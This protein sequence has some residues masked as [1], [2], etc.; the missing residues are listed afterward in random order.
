MSPMTN[1]RP[2]P[3]DTLLAEAQQELADAGGG[4]PAERIALAHALASARIATALES[5]DTAGVEIKV[6]DHV[7]VLAHDPIPVITN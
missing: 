1:K 2:E 7:S 4:T 5:I 3:A 6:N